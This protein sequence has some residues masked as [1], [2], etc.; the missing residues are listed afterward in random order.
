V[1]EY[2]S[3][4]INARLAH[5]VAHQWFGHKIFPSSY[6]DWWIVESGAE[7]MAGM[8]MAATQPQE[9]LVTGFPRMLAGWQSGAKQCAGSPVESANLLQGDAGSL[10]RFCLLYQKGP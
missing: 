1:T 9:N 5:E 3:W 6:R 4:G 10:E 2:F 8:A 7:Y